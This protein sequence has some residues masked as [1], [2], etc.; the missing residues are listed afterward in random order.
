MRRLADQVSAGGMQIL[1][2]QFEHPGN[3]VLSEPVD[4]QIG[5]NGAQLARDGQVASGMA[6]PDRR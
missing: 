2:F 4:P 1:P 5:V 6:E 3:R